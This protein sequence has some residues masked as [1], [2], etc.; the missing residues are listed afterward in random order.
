MK[1]I[2]LLVA[3]VLAA[4]AGPTVD[5]DT[6]SFDETQYATDLNECRG[7]NAVTFAFYGLGG[8]V[9]G[10][11]F[12]STEGAST[13]ALTGDSGEGALYGAIAGSV[14]GFGVGAY[15]ALDEQSQ[16]LRQCLASKGWALE[17][18]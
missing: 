17:P 13:G 8:A 12:G 9:I 1:R 2:A 14:I 7:G 16:K 5:R 10:A 11:M 3:M 18:T 15:K 6:A 4:C